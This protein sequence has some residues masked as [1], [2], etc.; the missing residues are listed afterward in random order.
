V[1]ALTPAELDAV[2]DPEHTEKFDSLLEARI[3]RMSAPFFGKRLN[4]ANDDQIEGEPDLFTGG[5]A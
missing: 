5:G 3:A 4:G 1:L 2:F